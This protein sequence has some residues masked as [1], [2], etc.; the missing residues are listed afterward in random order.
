MSLELNR[1]Y[2]MDC[3]EGLKKIDDDS[4]DFSFVDPPYNRNKDYGVYK[5][6]LP[7]NEY[8]SW[9]GTVISEMKRVSRNGI[10][11]YIHERQLKKT[12]N[13]IPKARLIIVHRR[14]IGGYD[15][16]YFMMYFCLLV[17]APPIE[18]SYSLWDD[19]RLCSEGYF[20]REQRYPHPAR[21]SNELTTK[22]I[23]TYTTAG[24]IIVDPC[25]G[26]GTTAIVC[27]KLKRNFICFE[28][29]P[30]YCKIAEERLTKTEPIKNLR[31]V[32]R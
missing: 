3:L 15:K 20:C 12:W 17:T 24:N 5:D 4:V 27:K 2:N 19:V 21:T 25:A 7:E 1:I 9:L 23:R 18:R 22:I 32:W 10:A 11:V 31:E 13:L 30:D 28:I 14:A 8:L 29:N 6:N 26:T 16:H